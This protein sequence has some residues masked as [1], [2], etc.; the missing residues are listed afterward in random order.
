MYSTSMSDFRGAGGQRALRRT[1]VLRLGLGEFWI[2]QISFDSVR[3]SISS[4]QFP[5]LPHDAAMLARS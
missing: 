5:F 3:F 4:T 2:F 1:G